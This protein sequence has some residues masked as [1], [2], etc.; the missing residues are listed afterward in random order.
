MTTDAIA[1]LFGYSLLVLFAL[2]AITGCVY[3]LADFIGK[4]IFTRMRRIYHLSSIVYWLH[5]YEKRGRKCFLDA[6][7]KEQQN[8]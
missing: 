2:S 3:L 1:F 5:H 8:G 6:N 7:E 4:E